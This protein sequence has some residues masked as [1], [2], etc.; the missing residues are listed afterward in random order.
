MSHV[1]IIATASVAVLIVLLVLYADGRMGTFLCRHLKDG[2]L[3]KQGYI[4][5]YRGP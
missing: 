5:C 1:R 2:W 4:G 3:A